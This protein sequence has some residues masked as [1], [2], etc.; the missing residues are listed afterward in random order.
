MQVN[1]LRKSPEAG[2]MPM[3]SMLN[4]RGEKDDLNTY[5]GS[6]QSLKRSWKVVAG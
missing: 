6:N 5:R 4:L 3:C 1:V 2:G